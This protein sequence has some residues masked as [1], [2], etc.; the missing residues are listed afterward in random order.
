MVESKRKTRMVRI[1][2]DTVDQLILI[3][4]K[5][6]QKG[7][8]FKTLGDMLEWMLKDSGYLDEE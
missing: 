6:K 1:N 2:D 8:E 5:M 4:I 7:R 3:K